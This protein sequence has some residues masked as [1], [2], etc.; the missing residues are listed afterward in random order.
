MTIRGSIKS[1]IEIIQGDI[2]R[3]TADA[4]VN[5][6]NRT[7]L[8]GG[9]VD[10]A[11]HSAAGPGLLEE[12]RKLGG[13]DTGEARITRGYNLPARWV[14]HGVGPVWQGGDR[15]EE[16]LL[17]KCYRNCF[18]LAEERGFKTIAFPAISTG[19]YRFP[20]ERATRI[21]V[22]ET[23][24]FLETTRTVQTVVFVCFS[25]G[26]YDIYQEVWKKMK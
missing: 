8:G 13:C 5:A 18:R 26:V 3:V 4:I 11:I 1:R 24:Q 14:I 15:N 16:A 20:L 22:D 6:A 19:V 17:A 12:C 7:L 21:A 25:R 23:V 2:T 9:G 10:G